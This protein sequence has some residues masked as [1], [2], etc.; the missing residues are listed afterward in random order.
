MN[1]KYFIRDHLKAFDNALSKGY[2]LDGVMYMESFEELQDDG[3]VYFFDVFKYKVSREKFLVQYHPLIFQ[4][5]HK[6][7]AVHYK[8]Q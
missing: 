8:H 3:N 7:G 4:T 2:K 6:D 5:Q 1:K